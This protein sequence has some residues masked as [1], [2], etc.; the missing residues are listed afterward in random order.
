[1]SAPG[2]R[3]R[4]GCRPAVEDDDGFTIHPG[5]PEPTTFETYDDHRMAMSLALLGLRRPGIQVRDPA[6]V[7]KTYPDYFHDLGLLA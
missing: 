5:T 1:M 7:A 2:R 6:C 4:R 3:G